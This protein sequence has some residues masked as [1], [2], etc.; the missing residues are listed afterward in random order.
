MQRGSTEGGITQGPPC[1]HV[2]LRPGREP[3]PP[4]SFLT[5]TRACCRCL[6]R[7]CSCPLW[8]PAQH[9]WGE[10]VDSG[11]GGLGPG[12]VHLFCLRGLST[13][14]SGYLEEVRMP[15]KYPPWKRQEIF[16]LF[17]IFLRDVS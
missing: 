4:R 6:G 5:L 9:R 2:T 15:L 14:R 11:L 8:A 16:F 7:P 17:A 12:S 10:F 3:S 1:P 13:G